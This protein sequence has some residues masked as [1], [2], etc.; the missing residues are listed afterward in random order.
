MPTITDRAMQSKPT[1]KGTWLSQPFNRGGGV[2]M[3]RITPNGE[4]LFYFRY[5]DSKGKRPFLPIGAYHPKGNNGG[6]TVAQAYEKAS[7]LSELCRSGVKDVGDYL[8]QQRLDRA[9]EAERTRRAA[10]EANE[11]AELEQQRRLTVR[12]LFDRW[13]SVELPPHD[14]ADGKR[15]GRKDAGAYSRAQFERHIF[16]SLGHMAIGD[17]RKAD[18]L[19]ILDQHRAVG[20]LRTC[21]VLLADMKQMMRFALSRELIAADPTLLLTKRDAGGADVERNRALSFEEIKSLAVLLDQAT[22]HVRSRHAVWLM[23]STGC[24]VGELMNAEWTNVDLKAR[25]WHLPV[26][27]NQRDHTIHLS[28]FAADHFQALLSTRESDKEG[29]PSPWVCPNSKGS[30][31]VDVKSLGKQLADRQKDPADRLSG[32]TK[33]AESLKLA[34]GKWTAHDLRRTAATLMAQ[35]GISSDVID[36]CLNHIN[37]NRVQ[38]TYI[39]T[40]REQEQAQAF[41]ALGVKLKEITTGQPAC[42]G[43]SLESP[44]P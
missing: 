1:A 6:L 2:F 24:R 40:R 37:Q 15:I 27:K 35:I 23:L 41:D 30:G 21:N 22:M 20:K 42:E 11:R 8:E 7:E 12:Q 38:R 44:T 10:I 3:G 9:Q 14:R 43:P 26:T 4:R 29:M 13:A 17:V 18:V 33:Q 19:A 5:T 36:E 31:P 34:G 39:R 16:P 32:R 28:D 25:T